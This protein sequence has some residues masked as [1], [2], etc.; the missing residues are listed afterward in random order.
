MPLTVSLRFYVCNAVKII[1]S[2]FGFIA[3]AAIRIRKAT[4]EKMNAEV[5]RPSLVDCH[6]ESQVSKILLY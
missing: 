4:T 6:A 1:N 5:M 2:T 3:S